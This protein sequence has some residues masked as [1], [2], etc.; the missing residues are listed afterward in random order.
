M[1]TYVS[2]MER[3]SA[4]LSGIEQ[5]SKNIEEWLIQGE[6]PYTLTKVTDTTP[7]HHIF[8][9]GTSND[10][11]Q[12][13]D[14]MLNTLLGYVSQIIIYQQSSPTK[15]ILQMKDKLNETFHSQNSTSVKSLNDLTQR[16][17]IIKTAPGNKSTEFRVGQILDLLQKIANKLDQ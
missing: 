4:P 10:D 2:E 15:Y 16:Y 17:S 7:K 6:I 1:L 11:I 14:N 9:L 13:Y 8:Q 12:V 5:Y 3:P